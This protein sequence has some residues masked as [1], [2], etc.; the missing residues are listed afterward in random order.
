MK[1]LI[2]LALSLTIITSVFV[3]TQESEDTI[4]DAA[5]SYKETLNKRQ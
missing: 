4:N 5:D 2:T 3:Y 1:S